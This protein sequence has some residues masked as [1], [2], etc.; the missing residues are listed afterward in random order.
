[1]LKSLKILQEY[2]MKKWLNIEIWN[3]SSTVY[4]VAVSRVRNCIRFDDAFRFSLFADD[5]LGEYY[6]RE[7]WSGSLW[8]GIDGELAARKTRWR[9]IRLSTA[10]SSGLWSFAGAQ[11][12]AIVS[13]T[14]CLNGVG[15]DQRGS[16]GISMFT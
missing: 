15:L 4:I 3:F 16:L 11:S 1:M 6:S 12:K 8:R 5:A 14:G 13:P 10:R 2:L 9:Y 7:R